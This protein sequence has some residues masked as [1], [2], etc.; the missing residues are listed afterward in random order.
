MVTL[1]KNEEQLTNEIMSKI[2]LSKDKKNL[3]S[4]VVNLSKC[5]VN[6]SKKVNVDLGDVKAQVVAIFDYSGSMEMKPNKLYSD[7][8]VQRTINRLV[9]VGLTCDDNGH[10]DS[11]LFQ[12]TYRKLEDITISNYEDYVKKIILK[13]GY[14]MGGTQYEPVLRQVIFGDTIKDQEDQDKKGG[15]FSKVFGKKSTP[16]DNANSMPEGEGTDIKLIMFI[17]DGN[18]SDERA[19]ERLIIESSKTKKDFIQFI[20]IGKASF[21]FLRKLDD[22]QGREYDNTGFSQ[23]DLLDKASDEELYN[24]IF[25]QFAN[26]LKAIGKK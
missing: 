2:N 21:N 11:Y 22:I 12:N 23:M 7:G 13:S 8:T 1:K 9:P 16:V 19:T 10:I 18:N 3:E 17:T 26:W 14:D 20:G 5:L 6:L 15:F 4:H 24:I 25:E